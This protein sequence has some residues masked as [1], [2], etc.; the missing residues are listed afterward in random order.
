VANFEL[1][2]GDCLEVM[3]TMPANSVDTIITD[4]PYGLSFMGK[5]WDHGIPG[6]AFWS[7][8]LRV[9][10][11]GAMLLAF[12]GSRTF[13]RLTCA[14]EDAGWEI[15]DCM[16]WLYGSGFPKSH[17]ISK[18]ID[19][20]GGQHVGWFGPWL[21]QERE[22]RGI[23]QR[24]LAERGGFYDKINHG[25]AVTNWELGYNIPTAEQ[26]NKICE[27]LDLPFA[28]IEE[29]EREVV[30]QQ[31][32]GRLAVAPGQ[33]MDRSMVTLD[34]TSPSTPAATQWHGWG[35]ALKPAHEPVIVA[36]KPLSGDMERG[37]IV[38]NLSQ[39]EAQL[40]LLSLAT[41]AGN[42]SASSQAGLDEAFAIAQWSADRLTSIRESLF[43]QMDT[44]QCESVIRSSWNTVS[45]WQRILGE[46]SNAGSMYTTSTES[47]QTIDL[48]TLRYLLSQTTLENIIKAEIQTL[49]SAQHALPVGVY[50]NAVSANINATRTLSALENAMS[51]AQVKHLEGIGPLSPN[52][53]PIILAMKPLDGTFAQNALKHGVA[54]LNVDGGRISVSDA[55]KQAVAKSTRGPVAGM[56]YVGNFGLKANYEPVEYNPTGRWPANLI[57]DEEAA[58][59]L[60]EMSGVSK[61]TGGNGSGFGR[62]GQNAMFQAS[63]KAIVHDGPHGLGKGDSGGASRFFYVAKASRS[64]REKGLEGMPLVDKWNGH[65]NQLNGSGQPAQQIRMSN[66]HPTVKPLALMRYLC[67]LTATPTGG[68]VLDPFMGSGTTGVAAMDTG[69][70]FIGIELE[71][72]YLEIAQRRIEDAAAQLH[73]FAEA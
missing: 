62:N 20:H 68:V 3:R 15:R 52:W 7:E 27:L 38:G 48:K 73:L 10:K 2:L 60:D 41:T 69:R 36:T 51:E 13:H 8:A 16:M 32:Q 43:A 35:T 12:G 57:L 17:D 1:H 40:W 64:E 34:I 21:R 46:V 28:R 58:G 24:E 25:G 59:M 11:P 71:A 29:A 72:E 9:A 30:G 37:I 23:S 33:G 14:I 18:G 39:M 5:Q 47:S 6:V 54:G 19:K 53:E 67:T 22:R 49:G 42:N 44:L 50:L 56:G 61:S 70:R 26:F 55:D 63:G 4:P 65:A 31:R 66:H 45:S